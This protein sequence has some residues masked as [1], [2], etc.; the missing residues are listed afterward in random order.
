MIHFS[1]SANRESI[2]RWGLDWR[3]MGGAPGIAGS[4]RPELPVVFLDDD[5]DGMFR[6]M[7]RTVTDMWAVDVTG[8]WIESG[9]DGWYLHG[10]PIP[11]ER[12]RLAESDLPARPRS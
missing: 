1:A 11:P 3:R 8:L 9:P 5:P 2:V 4:V 12:L 6:T 10:Q 7:G